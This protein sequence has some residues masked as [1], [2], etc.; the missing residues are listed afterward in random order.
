MPE[1]ASS[2][3]FLAPSNNLVLD[4]PGYKDDVDTVIIGLFHALIFP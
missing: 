4:G 2:D 3:G 1:H